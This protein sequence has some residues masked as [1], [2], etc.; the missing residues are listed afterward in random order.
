MKKYMDNNKIMCVISNFDGVIRWAKF[1]S[2]SEAIEWASPYY[3]N[4]IV[5]FYAVK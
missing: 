3:K 5:E 4:Y 2:K 1:D